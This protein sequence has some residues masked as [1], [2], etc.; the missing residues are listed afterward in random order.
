MPDRTWK[1][2]REEDRVRDRWK[3]GEEKR[4]RGCPASIS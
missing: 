4:E 1:K 3:G 2:R